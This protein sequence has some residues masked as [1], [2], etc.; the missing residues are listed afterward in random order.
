VEDSVCNPL[1]DE[2]HG[3]DNKQQLTAADLGCGTGALL[4]TLLE[5]F[6]RVLAID[7]SRAMLRLASRRLIGVYGELPR[8]LEFRC[9]SLGRLQTL[10]PS[11]DVAC[12]LN[13]VLNPAARDTVRTLRSIRS[14]LRPGGL[15]IGVFPALESAAEAFRFVYQQELALVGEHRAALGRARRRFA[16]NR[17]DF[18]LGLHETGYLR[19]KLFSRFELESWLAEAGFEG[20]RFSRVVYAADLGFQGVH[21]YPTTAPAIWHWYVSCRR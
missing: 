1:V 8:K 13:S 9:R 18:A 2:L 17:I 6:G 14:C 19:Q 16:A 12:A 21:R 10:G 3:L 11:I 7:S 15:L 5:A 20:Q 4:P